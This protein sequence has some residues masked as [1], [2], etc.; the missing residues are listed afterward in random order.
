MCVWVI[1]FTENHFRFKFCSNL[2]AMQAFL[3]TWKNQ[4][5][6]CAR[7]F[8][9]G[10]IIVLSS[11]WSEEQTEEQLKNK[12]PNRQTKKNPSGKFGLRDW[13]IASILLMK[14][15]QKRCAGDL[16]GRVNNSNSLTLWCHCFN[17]RLQPR[18]LK[19]ANNVP[20]KLFTIPFDCLFV[21]C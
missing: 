14:C 19:K 16:V 7:F 4:I 18:V 12:E 5:K 13:D 21:L 11:S 1:I 3:H 9:W 2:L 6:C 20:S 15:D 8:C 17:L 10:L